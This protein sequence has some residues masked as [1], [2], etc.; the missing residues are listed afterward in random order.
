LL[1]LFRAIETAILERDPDSEV[2]FLN[3]STYEELLG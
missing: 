2:T 3:D 1:A